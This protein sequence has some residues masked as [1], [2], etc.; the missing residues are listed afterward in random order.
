MDLWDASQSPQR[1]GVQLD[2]V[3]MDKLILAGASPRGMMSLMRAARVVAWLA[4]RTH[5]MPDDIQAR[6]ARRRLRHRV[7]FTPVYELRRAQIAD[8]L[9]AQILEKV[10]TPR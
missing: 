1:F 9:V 6:R 3:D 8:A 4:G 2:G 10:P 7:F 5:L